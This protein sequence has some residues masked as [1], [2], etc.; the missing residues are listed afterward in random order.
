MK[1]RDWRL[2]RYLGELN[3]LHFRH[4]RFSEFL[5]A[6]NSRSSHEHCWLCW[7]RI[8]AHAIHGEVE[9]DGY[10]TTELSGTAW[11]CNGCFR[12]FRNDFNFQSIDD[13]DNKLREH[14]DER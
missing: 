11:L 4:M 12:D 8:G 5:V 7:Q 9:E 6:Q 1:E 14:K 2:A 3:N 10:V 13:M